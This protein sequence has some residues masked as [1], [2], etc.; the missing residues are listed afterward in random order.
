[1]GEV[2]HYER[3]IRR[4]HPEHKLLKLVKGDPIV[5][6]PMRMT[7][8]QPNVQYQ[9]VAMQPAMGAPPVY[10]Q[11]AYAEE[12]QP[13]P[14]PVPAPA[15]PSAYPTVGQPCVDVTVNTTREGQSGHLEGQ[16]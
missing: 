1:M 11:P 4:E 8:I 12:G 3:K 16:A 7:V 13:G 5:V 10:A 14:E 6:P 9:Y 2:L 15:A